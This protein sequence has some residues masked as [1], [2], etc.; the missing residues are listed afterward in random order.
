MFAFLK[1]LTK[2]NENPAPAPRPA[3]P[4]PSAAPPPD[5]KTGVSALGKSSV[6]AAPALPP[7]AP[8]TLAP[9]SSQS[10]A[11]ASPEAAHLN[12]NSNGNLNGTSTAPLPTAAST[13]SKT[14]FFARSAK[15]PEAAHAL[16]TET[17]D[18]PLRELW[19]KLNPA[20]VQT[21]TGHP[22][23]GALLRVPANIIRSQVARGAVKIPYA[24]LR[25]FSPSGLFPSNPAKDSLEVEIPLSEVLPRLKPE[26]LAR[27]SNQRKIEVPAEIG[28]IFGPG[29]SAGLRVAGEKSPSPTPAPAKP[30]AASAPAHPSLPKPSQHAAPPAATVEATAVKPATAVAAPSQPGAVQPSASPAPSVAV[31]APMAAAPLPAAPLP[32]SPIVSET[33]ASATVAPA[34][35][36]EPAPLISEPIRAPSLDPALATLRPKPAPAVDAFKIEL[37]DVASFWTE[38]GRTEL[39]NLYRHSLEIPMA[40]LEKAMK[41]G[42][43]QFPWREV[44]PWVRLVPGNTLPTIADDLVVELPLAV[45]APRFIEH[46][47]GNKNRRRVEVA[48]DIPDLF[49]QKAP[50]LRVLPPEPAPSLEAAFEIEPAAALAPEPD[51]EPSPAAEKKFEHYGDIFGEPAKSDWSLAEIMRGTA[52]LRGVSGSIIATPD[53]LLI[54]GTWPDSVSTEAVAGFVPQ[55]YGRILQ[56]TKELKL[57]EPGHFTLLIENVPLRIFNTGNSYFTVLGRAGESLPEPELQAL[58]Q[59]LT[60]PN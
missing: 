3:A 8:K 20:I 23:P 55:M 31:A 42:K 26:V 46:R 11:P 29:S 56:Y 45:V 30:G 28:N 39:A 21:A 57:G 7:P 6:P 1:K 52:G 34:P 50:P 13:S 35:A 41:S 19:S 37:M 40:V 32:I 18:I 48:A 51:L 12:G 25:Q 15:Q 22:E 60:N 44:R 2:R 53:G 47:S 5:R 43:L 33:P 49:A 16:S 27:R 36:V 58:A 14:E 9:N 10:T 38:K 59:H 54:A 17:V 24:Q 4:S